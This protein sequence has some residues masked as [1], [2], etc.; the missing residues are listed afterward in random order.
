VLSFLNVDIL[1]YLYTC[2]VNLSSQ[3]NMTRHCVYVKFTYL[4]RLN[5]MNRNTLI[6]PMYVSQ[7]VRSACV[8]CN[9]GFV[10]LRH[11]KMI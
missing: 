4:M 3:N 7:I 2:N 10:Y 11:E 6:N 1:T 8:F 9:I 5:V